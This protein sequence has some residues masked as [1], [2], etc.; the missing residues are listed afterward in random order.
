MYSAAWRKF[1]EYYKLG[2]VFN[3]HWQLAAAVC[4]RGG[5]D[6]GEEEKSRSGERVCTITSLLATVSVLE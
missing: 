4:S 5:G 6:D 2:A 1:N 3:E